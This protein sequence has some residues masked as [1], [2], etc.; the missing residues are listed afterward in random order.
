MKSAFLFMALF[1]VFSCSSERNEVK[2]SYASG[3]VTYHYFELNEDPDI[4]GVKVDGGFPVRLISKYPFEL[5]K[6]F[7]L[8]ESYNFVYDGNS[9]YSSFG[10][11]LD[12]NCPRY[13]T[14]FICFT[15]LEFVIDVGALVAF[16][17]WH[18]EGGDYSVKKSKLSEDLVVIEKKVGE[19]VESK[20]YFS[21]TKG[22]VG[23]FSHIRSKGFWISDGEEFG[24]GLYTLSKYKKDSGYKNLLQ[25]KRIEVIE[26][27]Y[28]TSK[29]LSSLYEPDR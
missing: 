17:F 5:D 10:K 15:N 4:S 24:L 12:L 18:W 20:V 13:N 28:D 1:I 2:P 14:K 11:V 27:K 19:T 9:T 7:P 6:Y 16:E 8:Y 26:A 3:K 25:N 21:S 23:Y 22:L 29:L